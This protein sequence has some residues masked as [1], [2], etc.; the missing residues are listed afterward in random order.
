MKSTE[1]EYMSDLLKEYAKMDNLKI[2]RNALE[3][4]KI[5]MYFPRDDGFTYSPKELVFYVDNYSKST[6]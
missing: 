3:N 5:E 2:Q 1:I 4:A 6:K